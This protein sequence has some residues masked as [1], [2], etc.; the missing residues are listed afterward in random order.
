MS[1]AWIAT[2]RIH[3]RVQST[4]ALPEDEVSQLAPASAL[5]ADL[6]GHGD[7]IRRLC[8]EVRALR[9]DYEELRERIERL[10]RA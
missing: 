7:E 4:G 1:A 5:R 10:E 6:S 3:G 8:R 9:R 2:S